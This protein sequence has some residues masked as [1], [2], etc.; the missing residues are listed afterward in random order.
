LAVAVRALRD[1][2]AEN[3][4]L[5]EVLNSSEAWFGAWE[6]GCTDTERSV[7][8]IPEFCPEHGTRPVSDDHGRTKVRLNHAG[9]SG[10]GFHPATLAAPTG[11]EQQG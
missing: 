8:G 6:C 2:R 5:R 3:E 9:V 7:G 10:Y 11:Q 1:A 4:R